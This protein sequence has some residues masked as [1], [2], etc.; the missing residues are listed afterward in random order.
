MPY[1]YLITTT[2]V[3]CGTALAVAPLHR[4]GLLSNISFRVGLLLDE[5]TLFAFVWLVVWTA[6]PLLEGDIDTPVGW[7]GLVMAI[8]ATA[9][10]VV[11]TRRALSTRAICDRAL[12]ESLGSGWRHAIDS[13]TRPQHRRRLPWLRIVF[14]PFFRRRHDVERIANIRYGD[15]GRRNLLDVYRH[16]SHPSSAPVLIH[17]HGGHFNKGRKNTQ[18]LP[19]LYRFASQG[20]VCISANYRLSPRAEFPDHLIDAKKV[21]AWVRA[22]GHEF[23]ADPTVLFV[24]GSSAGAHLASMSALTPN[25]P[26]FQPG[27][28]HADTNVTAAIGLNG[29]FGPLDVPDPPSSPADYVGA[30]APPFL[31]VHGDHDTVVPVE[32][33]RL[34]VDRLRAASTNPVVYVEL[35]GAQHAFD[36]FHSIRFDSVVD[37]IDA[38]AAWVRSRA[39]VSSVGAPRAPRPPE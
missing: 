23:G 25:D 14:V 20:W 9:G 7:A 29:Y 28:E 39:N 34:F 38:F 26:R 4:P 22:R 6:Q 1:G 3:A 21:I 10:L 11:I 13:T 27:F 19:L 37:A 32:N 5:L 2:V 17:F 18:S 36:L 24:A 33:A 8:V 31:I 35:P 12:E 30:H 16:R 15:A